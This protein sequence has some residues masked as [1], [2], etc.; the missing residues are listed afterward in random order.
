MGLIEFSYELSK[1]EGK[2]GSPEKPLSDLGLLSYR[3]Y[4]AE[5]IVDYLLTVKGDTSID[6]VSQ[7]TAITH[8]DVMHTCQALQILKFVKGNY[9]IV[10]SEAVIEQHERVV[11]KGRRKINP[12]ALK[13]KPPQFSR[14]QLS[15]GF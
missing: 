12:D 10:L 9:V 2:V 3:A 8:A 5:K 6:E 14:A 7:R 4:W 11:K 13:W 1:K 15:F